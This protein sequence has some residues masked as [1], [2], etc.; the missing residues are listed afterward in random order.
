MKNNELNNPRI[1][2]NWGFWDA[3]IAVIYKSYNYRW[4]LKGF[5]KVHSIAYRHGFL[6]GVESAQLGEDPDS[7]NAAWIEYRKGNNMDTIEQNCIVYH[8]GKEFSAGGYNQTQTH[9]IAY[10]GKPLRKFQDG[11][12]ETTENFK[13]PMYQVTT[14]HGEIIGKLQI[15]SR[16]PIRNGIMMFAFTATLNDGTTWKGR[17]MGQGMIL[18]AK[19]YNGNVD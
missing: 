5:K 3:R 16:W 14:W 4:D 18:R 17:T 1:R 6:A 13:C 11:T 15:T 12:P 10:V 9:L 2:F 8:D 7:S 19:R